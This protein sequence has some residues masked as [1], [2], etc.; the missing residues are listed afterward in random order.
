MSIFQKQFRLDRSAPNGRPTFLPSATYD[1]PYLG[2]TLLT[3][4]LASYFETTGMPCLA[5]APRQDSRC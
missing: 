3:A 5:G 4:D 2:G 1:V